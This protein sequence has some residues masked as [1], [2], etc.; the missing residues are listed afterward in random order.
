[1]DYTYDPDNDDLDSVAAKLAKA[2]SELEQQKQALSE[3]RAKAKEDRAKVEA[4]EA[5]ERTALLEK[6]PEAKREALKAWS[7]DQ[8]KVAVEFLPPPEPVE[9]KAAETPEFVAP[10]SGAV[11]A[12]TQQRIS[13]E[14]YRRMVTDPTQHRRAVELSRAGLVDD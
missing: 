12:G 10:A 7:V 2:A 3:A 4:I 6:F 11:P 9:E 5:Q 8:L 14:E 13:Y 1:M